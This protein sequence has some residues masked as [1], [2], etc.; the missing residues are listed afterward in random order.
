MVGIGPATAVILLI[1]MGDNPERLHSA[2]SFAALCGVSPVERSS[3]RRNYRRRVRRGLAVL[4]LA[5]LD[6][7][8]RAAVT[9]RMRWPK[10]SRGRGRYAA[11]EGRGLR[12]RGCTRGQGVCS[13]ALFW[14]CILGLIKRFAQPGTPTAG[15]DHGDRTREHHMARGTA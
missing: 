9:M 11:D 12:G 14:L 1:T 15:M 4:R 8:G 7:V 13:V 2:A 3:G 10:C 5:V 6:G